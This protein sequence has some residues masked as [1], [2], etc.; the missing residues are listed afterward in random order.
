MK[1]NENEFE[2]FLK[3]REIRERFA[4]E[5]VALMQYLIRRIPN[6]LIDLKKFLKLLLQA[7]F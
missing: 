7:N 2:Y 4:I 3:T 1:D 5:D 6:I